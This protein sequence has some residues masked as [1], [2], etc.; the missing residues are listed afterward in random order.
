MRVCSLAVWL[1]LAAPALGHGVSPDLGSQPATPADGPSTA[2]TLRA[3]AL[4]L[5]YNLDHEQALATFKQSIAADPDDPAGY[6]L[7]ATTRGG[8]LQDAHRPLELERLRVLDSTS[9]KG[10]ATMLAAA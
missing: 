10:L 4:D 8:D 9:V 5:G 2:A 3:K 7:A 1:L 6:R